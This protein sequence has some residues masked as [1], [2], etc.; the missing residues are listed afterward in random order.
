MPA[1]TSLLTG[2]R[3]LPPAG[4]YDGDFCRTAPGSACKASQATP[5]GGAALVLESAD[6]SAPACQAG[7]VQVAA[8]LKVRA[9]NVC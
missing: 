2:P 7:V 8:W 6:T 3:S 4:G 5:L 9:G 1:W